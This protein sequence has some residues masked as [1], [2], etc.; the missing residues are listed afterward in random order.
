MNGSK[1][2]LMLA[3]WPGMGSVATLV[4]THLVDELVGIEIETLFN[5]RW[6]RSP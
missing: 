6:W 3:A 1:A 4:S 2:D 5:A